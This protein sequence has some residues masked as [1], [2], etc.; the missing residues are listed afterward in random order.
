MSDR[1]LAKSRS[2]QESGFRPEITLIG[3][4]A[5]VLSAIDAL[6]GMESP[7]QLAQSWLRFFGLLDGDFGRFRHHLR[8]AAAAHDWGKANDGFQNM[9]KKEGEQVVR[10]E[11]LSGLLLADLIADPSIL[12]WLRDAGIDEQIVLAADIGHHVKAGR[13]GDHAL[14][15]LLPS[16]R[17]RASLTFLSDHEDFK[18]IWR[19]V[20]DEV[21]VPCPSPFTFPG[22]WRD[23][24]D[25]Q[26]RRK[27]LCHRLDD[28]Q[29]RL[30]ED[31]VGRRW[32][33]AVRAGL[34]AA[35]A[36]GSAVVRMEGDDEQAEKRIQRWVDECFATTLTGNDVWQK[37]VKP[38]IEELRTHKRWDDAKGFK[39]GDET[40][41][42]QFQCEVPAQGPGGLELDQDLPRQT[43]R[44]PRPVSLPDPG[45][46]HRRVPR[47]RFLGTRGRGRPAQRDRQL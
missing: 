22:R 17:M 46:G 13:N 28:Q 41:F 44:V 35:D 23:K 20:Q 43:A 30:R 12:A 18:A 47:L 19:M 34:I 38:R 32:I 27:A 31:G 16:K 45:D 4:T 33:A 3:H 24:E 36:V 39:F 25:I 6:F 21:G 26:P 8:V 42:N 2:R 10:H 15:A 11:H 40:G 5:C 29:K 9:V 37:V 1:L 14:G 7:T